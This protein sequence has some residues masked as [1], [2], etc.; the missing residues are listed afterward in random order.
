MKDL[1]LPRDVPVLARLLDGGGHPPLLAFDYDGVLAPI[2]RDPAGASMARRTRA[3]L[4]ELAARF[5]VAV[6]SGRS[7]AKLHRVVGTVAPFL[8]GNHGYEYL[9]RTPVPPGV[10]PRVR[11]WEAR[12]M[13]SLEGVP[14]IHLEHKHSTFAIHYDPDLDAHA[15]E[16]VLRAARA[17]RGTR[18]VLGKRL[19]NVLPAAFPTKGDA[20]RKLLRHLRCRRALFVG[21][22]VTDED[23]FALPRRL[24]MGVHVGPGPSRAEWRLGRRHEVDELLA[25][26]LDLARRHEAEETGTSLRLRR[27]GR[28]SGAPVRAAGGSP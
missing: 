5:P 23:V 4:Q 10:L 9:H 26:L 14:G 19:V 3:L 11:Q 7:F 12:M 17:L 1:L 15:G 18:F 28:M 2:I 21:D 27:H 13:A 8:I 6:I 22:D 16:K 24:V 25:T 20:V